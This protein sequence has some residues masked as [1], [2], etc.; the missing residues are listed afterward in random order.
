MR[1]RGSHGGE[2][3]GEASGQDWGWGAVFYVRDI[4]VKLVS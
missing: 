3:V 2:V 1:W 4:A